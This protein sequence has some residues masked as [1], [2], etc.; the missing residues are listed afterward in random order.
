MYIE[1]KFL[2]VRYTKPSFLTKVL[3]N[4]KRFEE[5]TLDHLYL[6]YHQVELRQIENHYFEAEYA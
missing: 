3:P 4:T 6:V 1:R 5:S 2:S